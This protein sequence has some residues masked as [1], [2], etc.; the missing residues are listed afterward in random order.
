MKEHSLIGLRKL[1]DV[2]DLFRAAAYD[3]AHG[4]HGALAV[5]ERSDRPVDDGARLL[6]EQPL[7]RSLVPR[8]RER[9]P[10]A[11]E[12]PVLPLKALGRDC[13]PLVLLAGERRERH[14]AALALA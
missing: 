7:L 12:A 6:R 8:L 3:V 2:T 14:R 13:R 11:G 9:G 5:G 10:A 4:D 1:E